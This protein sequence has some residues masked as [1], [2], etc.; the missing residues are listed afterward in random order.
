[1]LRK[2]DAGRQNVIGEVLNLVEVNS[3]ADEAGDNHIA[4]GR[5]LCLPWLFFFA[6]VFKKCMHSA[7]LMRCSLARRLER[8][9]TRATVKIARSDSEASDAEQWKAKKIC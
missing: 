1:M 7:Y 6:V 8:S 2:G 4:T 5:Y 3:L 9:K